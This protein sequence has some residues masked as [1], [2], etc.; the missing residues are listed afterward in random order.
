MFLYRQKQGGLKFAANVFEGKGQ[1][2]LSWGYITPQATRGSGRQ[3]DANGPLL[4]LCLKKDV[5]TRNIIQ[6]VLF[7][8]IKGDCRE[9]LKVTPAYKISFFV[10]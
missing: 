5:K 1:N 9:L 8:V 6:A 3:K 2:E 4:F 10:V 7:W